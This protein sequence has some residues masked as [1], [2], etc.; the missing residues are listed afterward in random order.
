MRGDVRLLA[1]VLFLR[2]VDN[3]EGWSN[4][5]G[6]VRCGLKCGNGTSFDG[7]T[8]VAG[9][10]EGSEGDLC[11]AT[12]S[13]VA[14]HQLAYLVVLAD[15]EEASTD[16]NEEGPALLLVVALTG[17]LAAFEAFSDAV[18]EVGAQEPVKAILTV[19]W[20]RG[21]EGVPRI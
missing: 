17:P 5:R 14:V 13:R 20:D 8:R 10:V 16:A 2:R 15:L 21:L 11:A 3:R 7:H 1:S 4:T 6:E 9:R 12:H 18:D 19:G